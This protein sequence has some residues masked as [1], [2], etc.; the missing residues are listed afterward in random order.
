MALCGGVLLVQWDSHPTNVFEIIIGECW[1]ALKSSLY[2]CQHTCFSSL[3]NAMVLSLHTCKAQGVLLSDCST[4]RQT[5]AIFT[6]STALLCSC[7]SQIS[8]Q[9]GTKTDSLK[10]NRPPSVS[11]TTASF[12]PSVMMK[13]PSANTLTAACKEKCTVNRKEHNMYLSYTTL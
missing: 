1:S 6:F 5:T 12:R 4:A 11:F 13:M 10:A 7:V 9:D 2:V 8:R 3:G